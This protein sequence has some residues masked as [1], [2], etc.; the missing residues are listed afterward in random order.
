MELNKLILPGEYDGK[1]IPVGVEVERI[2]NDGRNIEP[3]TLF[4]CHEGGRYDSHVLLPTLKNAGCLAAVVSRKYA[5]REAGIPL[6]P[7]ADTGR[8]EAFAVSRFYGDP[9]S[10]LTLI[11]VTGTN[12]KTSVA[13]MLWS[14]LSDAGIPCGLIGTAGYRGRRGDETAFDRFHTGEAETMTTPPPLTLYPLLSAM[15][16]SGITHAVIEVSSQALCASRVSPLRFSVSVFTNLTPE[17]L[18]Y[19]GTMTSYLAAKKILFRQSDVAVVNGDSPWTDLLLDGL[20]CRRIDCGTVGPGDAT[21]KD[22]TL[23]G[24]HGVTYR[25][26]T[27]DCNIPV[28]LPIPGSFAVQNSLLSLTAARAL[29][30]DTEEAVA[31][32]AR[33]PGVPGRMEMIDAGGLPFSVFIDYAHTEAA[34]RSLLVSV[35]SFLQPGGRIVLL[36]GCGGDRDPGKRSEM[37]KTAEELADF[38]VVTSDNSRSEDPKKIILDILSGMVRPEK[39]RVI[40]KRERAIAYAIETAREGDVILL[41]GKGHEKY[42]I[43]ADGKRP[44]DEKKI[45]QLALEA[46]RNGHTMEVDA[47]ENQN[48]GAD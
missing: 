32:L 6:I 7:V 29:G 1:E 38:T 40:V 8:A 12:G 15:A 26:E 3:G 5:G 35:R 2:G 20:S 11:G 18:D 36:F 4:F 22:V 21:A 23:R 30:V 10:R 28:F 27:K 17:H 31:A 13:S 19:H 37:G 46:R 44:F 39:R 42:E 14:I 34:L 41:V 47:N 25:Y 48:R 43:D 16:D 24:V 9:G 45:A 33:F